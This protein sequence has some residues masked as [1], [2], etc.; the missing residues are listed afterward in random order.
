MTGTDA[1]RSGQDGD[2]AAPAAHPPV[3]GNALWLLGGELVSKLASIV[4]VV[5]VARVL[6]VREYGWF[7]FATAFVPLILI[8]GSMGLHQ[9]AVRAMVSD[10]HRAPEVFASGLVV[11]L[12]TAAAAIGLT[13]LLA[14]AFLDQRQAVITVIV[15]GVALALDATTSYCSSIFEAFGSVRQ[16]ATALMIN[17]V[18]STTLALIALL[19]GSGLG[20]VLLAYTLGSAAG[21]G[22]ALRALHRSFPDVAVRSGR[23]STAGQL[24]RA[25]LPL[26]V[27]GLLNMAL[28]RVDTLM[29]AGLLGAT[30]VGLYGVAFRFYESF[31]FVAFSLGEACFPRYARLGKV[32]GTVPTVE[33]AMVLAATAYVPLFVLS[34]FIAPWAVAVVFGERYAQ[35]APAVPWLTLAAA[36]FALTYQ[37]R[38]ALVGMGAARSVVPVAASALVVNVALNLVLI[39]R[40]GIAGAAVATAVSAAVEVVLTVA[41]LG[42]LRLGVRLVR[43]LAGPVTAGAL[44]AAVLALTGAEG[45]VALST[46]VAL[47]LVLLLVTV[48]VLPAEQRAW[49]SGV[50]RRGS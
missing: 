1:E 15:V 7:T 18:G 32:R 48:P 41:A 24:V 10:R 28:L 21:L 12:G 2:P 5:I 29:V 23:V 16:L 37:A 20:F 45:L 19:S 22:Y 6:G 14:P 46:G 13:A 39:P 43:S 27:A 50:V 8:I 40:T 35:A 4:F 36:L 17:R 11:R 26:G 31:L 47:Y 38:S 30:A 44:M 42:R 25:G 49:L 9:S 3:A 33:A 34:L